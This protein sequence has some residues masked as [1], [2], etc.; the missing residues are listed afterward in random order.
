MGGDETFVLAGEFCFH[1]FSFFLSVL[2]ITA[3][4]EPY[5]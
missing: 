1:L 2:G 5:L 4:L 3:S